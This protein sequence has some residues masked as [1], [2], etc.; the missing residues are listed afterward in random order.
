ME[1]QYQ[2]FLISSSL[3]PGPVKE[4]VNQLCGGQW[5]SGKPVPVTREPEK[6]LCKPLAL[7]CDP[8]RV[9]VEI[10]DC[11]YF[12]F[13]FC[14]RRFETPS[15]KCCVESYDQAQGRRAPFSMSERGAEEKGAGQRSRSLPQ[16]LR[17]LRPLRMRL[18][19]SRTVCYFLYIVKPGKKCKKEVAEPP[20]S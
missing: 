6:W 20:V 5:V 2:D 12:L 4:G 16:N 18:N 7:S 19:P 1:Q 15:L 10:G 14:W 3:T 13:F 9:P 17:N 11:F 8:P